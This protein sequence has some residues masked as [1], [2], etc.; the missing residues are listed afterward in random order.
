ME[1]R[2]TDIKELIMQ[3]RADAR[4][5]GGPG[6]AAR[7]AASRPGHARGGLRVPAR[8]AGRGRARQGRGRGQ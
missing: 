8:E 3:V 1:E 7:G 5:Q 6:G 4:Q 2:L